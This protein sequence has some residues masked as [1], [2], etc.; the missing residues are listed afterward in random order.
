MS[1]FSYFFVTCKS[2]TGDTIYLRYLRLD[3]SSREQPTFIKETVSTASHLHRL[4]DK[5]YI[6]GLYE[7]QLT[8]RMS[9]LKYFRDQNQNIGNYFVLDKN[10]INTVN[11]LNHTNFCCTE[12]I[13][14][15]RS[16][17]NYFESQ[18]EN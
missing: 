6:W 14:R 13:S 15:K 10:I 9:P 3:H 2:V 4:H 11:I 7:E 17:L 16:I 8:F 1:S 5:L 18:S 12:C